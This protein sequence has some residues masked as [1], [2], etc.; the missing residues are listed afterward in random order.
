V[1]RFLSRPSVGQCQKA[2]RHK[3]LSV[4]VQK[5]SKRL[6]GRKAAALRSGPPGLFPVGPRG[7][8]QGQNFH[9]TTSR[10]PFISGTFSPGP[11][12]PLEPHNHPRIS[13]PQNRRTPFGGT[14]A[15][16]AISA[17]HSQIAAHSRL[18]SRI[19]PPVLQ[20]RAHPSMVGLRLRTGASPVLRLRPP[21]TSK[22]AAERTAPPPPSISASPPHTATF[23]R[24]I[25]HRGE[26]SAI[27]PPKA[28]QPSR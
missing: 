10:I 11:C 18:F 9:Q 24:T 28:A 25:K 21:Q 17:L 3:F 4:S 7:L 26:H 6:K 23:T 2:K 12:L 5:K 20:F 15:V 27:S 8:R 14:A 19:Y 13:I 16:S 1:A 22:Q